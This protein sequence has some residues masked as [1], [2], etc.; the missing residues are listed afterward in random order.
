MH[1]GEEVDDPTIL[2][3]TGKKGWAGSVVIPSS[4]FL[5]MQILRIVLPTDP[6]CAISMHLL[7][8][9]GEE[10]DGGSVIVVLKHLVTPVLK[11]LHER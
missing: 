9:Q 5:H 11:T 3:H 8:I 10:Q 2:P 4:L 1:G 7:I 6:S